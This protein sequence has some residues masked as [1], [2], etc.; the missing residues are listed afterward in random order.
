MSGETILVVEDEPLVAMEIREDLEARGFKV[1]AVLARGEE[2]QEAVT[3]LLPDLVVMDIRIKGTIDGIEAARRIKEALDLPILYLTA[4]S[5]EATLAR[6]VGT[7]PEAFLL[8]PFNEREL[9]ANITMALARRKGRESGAGILEGSLALVN[10]LSLPALVLDR[11]GRLIHANGLARDLLAGCEGGLE[12]L[13]LAFGEPC[14]E[15]SRLEVS[16]GSGLPLFA[17]TEPLKGR[18][19]RLLG[20]LVTLDSMSRLERAH[21]ETNVKAINEAI[22]SLLPNEETILPGFAVA[23]FLDPCVS[24]AGD[25]VEA[26]PLDA[27][28]SVFLGLDVMGHGSFASLMAY[29]TRGLVRELLRDRRDG[30]IPGPARLLSLLNEGYANEGEGR[31]FFTMVFGLLDGQDGSW[32]LARAGHPPVL[33]LPRRG[34]ARVVDSRGGA[35]GVLPML[36]AEEVSGRLEIGDRLF[37][38][39]DGFLEAAGGLEFSSSVS[40]VLDFLSDHRSLGLEELMA[41]LRGLAQGGQP[42]LAPRDDISLLAIERLASPRP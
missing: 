37:V 4:N 19:G 31:P 17:H 16:G 21:L 35:V 9:V 5:D 12:G 10:A 34:E 33:I 38:M 7:G 2:V 24:G 18:D 1:A 40:R 41:S 30:N 23:A 36:E 11:E 22:A 14:L 13:G 42:S 39:S 28:H 27:R 8:K 25:L 29:S 6:A 3:R 32:R 20:S 26:Y 15:D